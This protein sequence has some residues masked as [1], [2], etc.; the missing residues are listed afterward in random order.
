VHAD[1]PSIRQIR[2]TCQL[3]RQG[4]AAIV[5][6]ESTYSLMC[7][8]DATHAVAT[9]RRIK[10]QDEHHL[11]SLVCTDLAAASKYV[12]INNQAHRVLRRLLPGPYTCILPAS[13]K[14]PRRI[15]GRRRDIG[16]RISSHV[17]CLE[18]MRELGSP[19]LASTLQFPDQEYPAS[20]PDDFSGRV[21]CHNLVMLD[22]GWCGVTTTTV[23]DLCGDV[24]VLIRK[25]LGR[26]ED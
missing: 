21:K 23:L 7:L 1:R 24:P 16:I 22:S 3:L 26:W 5:P 14:L 19:L 2:R 18:V 9:I 25:G 12:I 6:T 20:D 11:W 10:H 13:S 8:P 17:V 15:F 4:V